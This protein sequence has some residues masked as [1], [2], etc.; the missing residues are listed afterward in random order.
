MG[1]FASRLK[2]LRQEKNLRQKDLAVKLDLAQTTIANYEQDTR[3]PNQKIL[4]KIATYF[5]VSVDYLL[6]R[7]KIRKNNEQLSNSTSINLNDLN[8]NK[9]LSPLAE[10]YLTTLLQGREHSAHKLIHEAIE[11]GTETK[12]IYLEVFE[13]SLKELGELWERNEIT[14]AQEHYFTAA[15]ESIMSQ[16]C[17]KMDSN[18]QNKYSVVSLSTNGEFHNIGIRMVTDFL[19]MKGWETY[20]LGGNVPTQ[21]VIQTIQNLEADL[22]AISVTIPYN[23]EAAKNLITAVRSTFSKSEVKVIVGGAIFNQNSELWKEIEADGFA[24][25]AQEAVK[26]ATDLVNKYNLLKE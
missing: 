22:L 10:E 17:P 14:V 23:I 15:T 20:Y 13:P 1:N 9:P 5:N 12:D 18:N 19:A 25:N 21:S 26:V 7:T 6:G 24:P 16:I 4:T 2:K 8:K 3:F 11:K